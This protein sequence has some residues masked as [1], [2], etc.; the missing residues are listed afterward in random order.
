MS[1]ENFINSGISRMESAKAIDAK[2]YLSNANDTLKYAGH[3]ML[4]VLN[5]AHAG[6]SHLQKSGTITLGSSADNDLVL[7]ASRIAP[8]HVELA[9]QSGLNSKILVKPVDAPVTLED[10]SIV[11]VGQQAEVATGE[12]ITFGDTEICLTRIADPKSFV[13]PGIRIFAFIC[14]I[15]MIPLVFSIAS[16]FVGTV[17]EAGS[18]VASTVTSTVVRTS[19]QLL[20][21]VSTST[22]QNHNEAFAWTVRVKLEDLQ[23]NHKL[24][25][26]KTADGSIRVS[27]NISD[28]ELPR[29][30]SFL[31]WY[32]STSSFPPLIRD[33]SRDNVSTDLPQIKSVWLDDN[34]SVF[35]KDGT[36]GNIGS[37][38]KAGWKI[39]S[40]D[41][42]NVMIER[43]GSV[44]SLTY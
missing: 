24:R 8:N 28:K 16:G 29:W 1:M 36:V 33:V 21:K 18:R 37:S 27:G 41:E 44:I 19:D 26:V 10:G 32:D 40:I 6:S 20:G 4:E 5:G 38:I 31:Q 22:E 17:A 43:D 12:V 3:Y 25:T 11:E 7:Y 35:F 34:P 13:K 23:L 39:V 42:T 15:A 14:L 9:L 2:G 30:T